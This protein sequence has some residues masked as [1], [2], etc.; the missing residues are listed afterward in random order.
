MNPYKILGVDKNAS[1]DE[2]KKA[3]R[4][5]ALEHHPDKGGNEE[6]FKQIN[7]AYS[8]IS[9]SNKRSH[10]DAMRG[11][12]FDF[13][14]NSPFGNMFG[15]MFGA[16][17][18]RRRPKSTSDGDVV[19]DL[20]LTLDQIKHGMRQTAIFEKNVVCRPCNGQG[21]E[22]REECYMC[23]GSGTVI[24]QP[25]AFTFQQ[26]PCH[27]CRGFGVTFTNMCT[28]CSGQGVKRVKD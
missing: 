25:N 24:S 1:Q 7:E 23:D 27:N 17:K 13:F 6:K 10:H 5:K 12:D 21:G 22:G 2:I 11:M 15:E 8:M 4:K 14:N 28:V 26:N 3:F 16:K 9:N 18:K 20:R 19:F